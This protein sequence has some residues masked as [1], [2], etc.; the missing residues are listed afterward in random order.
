MAGGG[1][2]KS[3]LARRVVE[4]ALRLFEDSPV[5]WPLP[6]WLWGF[7]KTPEDMAKDALGADLLSAESIT[8]HLET[9]DFLL[10]IDGLNELGVSL[11]SLVAFVQSPSGRKTSLVVCARPGENLRAEFQRAARRWMIVE[12]EPLDSDDCLWSFLT[13][14]RGNEDQFQSIK[15]N[16][17]GEDGT[18]NQLFVRMVMQVGDARTVAD[19][20]R[21]Y[22]LKL[23][24]QLIPEEARRFELLREAGLWC[25]DS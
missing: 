20:F 4:E 14:Y 11:K 8:Q 24:K 3:A 21:G 13:H 2:G 5:R 22:F 25:V 10:A 18:Y 9:G 12:P 1:R 7:G 16:F 23:F 19:L 6:S 15:A 17:R